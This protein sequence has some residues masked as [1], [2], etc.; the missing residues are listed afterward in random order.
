MK[1]ADIQNLSTKRVRQ[2]ITEMLYP[3]LIAGETLHF[4][5]S[6]RARARVLQ[7]WIDLANS[8]PPSAPP[9]PELRG[10]SVPLRQIEFQSEPQKYWLAYHVRLL[11]GGICDRETDAAG[12][13]IPI[14]TQLII[15][16]PAGGPIAVARDAFARFIDTL[17]QSRIPA[18]RLRRCPICEKFL[19][20][21]R[22]DQW[23]CGRRCA[24]D[25]RVKQWREKASRYERSRKLSKRLKANRK[26]VSTANRR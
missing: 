15:L 19:V 11:L 20:A 21:L 13:I 4:G 10:M 9:P 18:D 26:R 25:Y 2:S 22:K 6:F 1:R 17:T 5:R 7:P 12:T 3:A 16:H 14:A 23:T 8:L 24:N